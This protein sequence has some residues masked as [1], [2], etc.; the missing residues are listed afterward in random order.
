MKAKNA[1]LLISFMALAVFAIAAAPAFGQGVAFQASSLPVQVRGEGLTETIGAVVLQATG[2]GTVPSGS[3][4]TI[5]YS[6][7]IASPSSFTAQAGLSCSIGATPCTNF[8]VSATGSQYTVQVNTSTAFAP[9]N[10]IEVSQ[11]RM[12]INAL[13]S[14]TTT[15]TATLSGTSATPVTNPITFT[16]SQVVVAS[17][18][19]PSVKGSIA[20]SPTPVLQ[21]CSIA[22]GGYTFSVKAGENYPAAVT[23][24]T[25]ETNFTGAIY[26]I[27]NGSLVNVS[28]ANVPS[29]LAVAVGGYTVTFNGSSLVTTS[30]G[31][32]PIAPQALGSPLYNATTTGAIFNGSTAVTTAASWPGSYTL[33]LASGSAVQ[34]SSGGTLSW[35][36]SVTGD[37]TSAVEAFT[38]GFT[39]GLPTSSGAA[40]S[41]T[42]G[43]LASIGTVVTATATV[44]LSPSSGVVS[45]ATNN[46]GGGTVATIGD[47]VT[48][49]LFPF[50]TNQ[51][52]FDT[53]VM[54]SN[55]SADKTAFPTGGAAAQS[56]TCTMT[57]YPTDLTTQTSSS[58]GTAGTPSQFT[59]PTIPA[60]GAY[61]FAQSTS[62]F[63][64]QSGYM[65]AVCRF[66]DAH[67]FS[68]VV[69]GTPSTGTISQGLLA[70]VIP[71]GSISTG[72]L[73]NPGNGGVAFVAT[74]SWE[75][76]VH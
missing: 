68:F 44:S 51:A 26:T 36:F 57:F 46:E 31:S 5:V 10:Y 19:N 58:S 74:G 30:G 14:G 22:G 27:S 70:L 66:L 34:T 60:G 16:Q 54:I 9:G 33:S 48:N 53:T 56:G 76:L 2:S 52:G 29:G 3:S 32:T 8:T 20:T 28:I 41:G 40:I 6:G 61:S 18:V 17:I 47:C 21:T 38:V 72:R 37:S 23:S 15:V 62:S 25:D 55:T 71:N 35:T 75:G 42:T 65:F 69:N 7:A 67:A 49:L 59:T 45:F 24:S 1:R 39:I 11:I 43:S 64:G 4:I 13:G 63:K 12:N 50:S 73:A